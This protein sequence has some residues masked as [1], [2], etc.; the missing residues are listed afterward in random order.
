MFGYDSQAQIHLSSSSALTFGFGSA[1]NASTLT[2]V[3]LFNG[4]EVYEHYQASCKGR[5]DIHTKLMRKYKDIHESL[6]YFLLVV[7]L[8]ISH[9]VHYP[10]TSVPTSLLGSSLSMWYRPCI[11][12][13]YC[14]YNHHNKSGMGLNIIIEYIMDLILSGRPMARVCFK[15]YGYISMTQAIFFLSDFKIGH[16]MKTPPRSVF[17]VQFIDTIVPG[18]I[19]LAVAWWLLNSIDHICHDYLSPPNS[20]YWFHGNGAPKSDATW[21]RCELLEYPKR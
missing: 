15:V 11:Y 18:T 20:H 12:S 14:H 5:D 6:F 8:G 21:E 4:R 7:W 10:E 1:T 17:L 19:I 3:A 16:Y 9:Y 2:H 13:S